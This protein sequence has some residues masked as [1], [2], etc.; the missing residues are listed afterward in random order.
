MKE[1]TGTLCCHKDCRKVSYDEVLQVPTPEPTDTYQPLSYGVLLDMLAQ[2]AAEKGL[3]I[4]PEKG[5]YGL[6]RN[7]EKLFGLYHLNG[8]DHLDGRVS[9]VLGF[10]TSHDKTM[11]ASVCFGSRVFVCD[12]MAFTASADADGISGKAYAQHRS[13]LFDNLRTRLL[14]GLSMAEPYMRFQ[15]QFYR[16]MEALPC[17]DDMAYATVVRAA[18]ENVIN[19]NAIPDVCLDWDFQASAPKE[20]TDKVWHPEFQPRNIWSLFNSFTEEAKAFQAK[21][22]VEAAK[23]SLRLSEFFYK[24]FA[25]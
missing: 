6:A 25:N 10:R 12:N 23:R 7:G 15:E 1:A 11:A 8:F 14:N 20:E 19:V 24:R 5:Q 17:N 2:C 16:K 4:S 21:N 13:K 18:R 22:P 9:L 3:V